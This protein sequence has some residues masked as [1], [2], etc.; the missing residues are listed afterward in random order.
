MLPQPEHTSTDSRP[1]LFSNGVHYAFNIQK[2]QREAHVLIG[3]LLRERDELYWK[4]KFLRDRDEYLERECSRLFQS[5]FHQAQLLRRELNPDNAANETEADVLFVADGILMVVEC[6]AGRL[7]ASSWRGGEKR[8][9]KDM[10]ETVACALNQAERFVTELVR[11]GSM[12]VQSDDH[13]SLRISADQF[14]RIFSVSV[15]LEF[16]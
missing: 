14:S 2:L 12:V 16:V 5:D 4:G 6:K 11:R 15:T 10:K 9:A 8:L 7:D 13:A 3:D 1:I